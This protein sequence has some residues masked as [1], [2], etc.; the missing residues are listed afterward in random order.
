MNWFGVIAAIS[1]SAA[2]LMTYLYHPIGE[3]V[4]HNRMIVWFL[5]LVSA[6]ST[7]YSYHK[8]TDNTNRD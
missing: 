1:L 7:V 3:A 6:T 4:F 5:G 8:I 2:L